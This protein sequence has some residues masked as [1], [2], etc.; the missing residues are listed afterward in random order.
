MDKDLHITMFVAISKH[1][2]P[3]FITLWDIAEQLTHSVLQSYGNLTLT[4]VTPKHKGLLQLPCQSKEHIGSIS[5]R[6][7]YKDKV[8]NRYCNVSAAIFK[9]SIRISGGVPY[10]V[11]EE[12]REYINDDA[13]K[14]YAAMIV[15]A[16]NFWTDN[17]MDVEDE[18]QLVNINAQT[19]KQPIPRFITFCQEKLWRNDKFHR[20]DLPFMY[21]YGAIATCHVYPLSGRNCSA[22]LQHTGAI[23]YMGFKEVDMLHVFSTMIDSELI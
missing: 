3:R 21:E 6:L 23:Q 10:S 16:I 15:D 8:A 17:C 18:V 19:R 14:E 11:Q 1:P 5:L 13:L 7:R 9:S 4:K 20:V 22:K 12:T 2:V